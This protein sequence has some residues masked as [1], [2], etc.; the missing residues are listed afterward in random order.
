MKTW[1][2]LLLVLLLGLQCDLWLSNG[3]IASV[4]HLKKDVEQQILKNQVLL[5]RNRALEAQVNEL[6]MGQQALEEKARNELG[7]LNQDETLYQVIEPDDST[8]INR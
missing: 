6:K 7:M 2:V 8:L 3:G 4:L 1:I 5:K